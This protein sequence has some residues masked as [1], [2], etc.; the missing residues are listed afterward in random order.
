MYCIPTSQQREDSALIEMVRNRTEDF[1]T[2]SGITGNAKTG[3][4]T[5][6]DGR[7]GNMYHGPFPA[8]SSTV[9]GGLQSKPA[10]RSAYP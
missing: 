7:K 8:I 5:L 1:H 6:P 10:P 4:Y 3:D 2:P 9:P